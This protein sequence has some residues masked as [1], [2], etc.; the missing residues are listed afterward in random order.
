M[1]DVKVSFFLEVTQFP[2]R[3]VTRYTSEF[4]EGRHRRVVRYCS[5]KLVSKGRGLHPPGRPRPVEYN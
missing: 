2:K 3:L 4:R 5:G 1:T